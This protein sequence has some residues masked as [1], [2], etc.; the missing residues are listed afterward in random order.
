MIYTWHTNGKVKT[1]RRDSAKLVIVLLLCD[2][3]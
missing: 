3:N 1:D 2:N